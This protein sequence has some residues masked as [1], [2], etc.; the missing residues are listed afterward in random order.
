ML[1]A[2]ALENSVLHTSVKQ[3]DADDLLKKSSDFQTNSKVKGSSGFLAAVI[4]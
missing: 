2:A 4:S 1:L 3:M